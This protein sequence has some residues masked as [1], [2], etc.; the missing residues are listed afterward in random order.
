MKGKV[1]F[2]REETWWNTLREAGESRKKSDYLPYT[3]IQ[4]FEVGTEQPGA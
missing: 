2:G 1:L 4:R 3:P